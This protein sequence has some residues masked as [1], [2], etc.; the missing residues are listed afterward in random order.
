MF[1]EVE[2]HRFFLS[3]RPRSLGN[4][5][6]ILKTIFTHQVAHGR[7]CTFSELQTRCSYFASR[8]V[9]DFHLSYL[10]ANGMVDV[11]LNGRKYE[12]FVQYEGLRKLN[13]IMK[14]HKEGRDE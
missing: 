7:G 4:R 12:H 11:E 10:I 9:I 3:T 13:Q 14:D 2:M 1:D 6:K 5:E 8:G